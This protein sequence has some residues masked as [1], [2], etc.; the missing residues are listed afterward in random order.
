MQLPIKTKKE[1]LSLIHSHRERIAEYGVVR[2]G[3][4]GS[5]VRDEANENSDVDLFVEFNPSFKTLKNF[6]G[7]ANFF[8]ELSGRKVEIITPESLNKFIGK[9]ITEQVEYVSI[10]A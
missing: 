10:A 5:F 1:L 7:L 2:L 4:F 3:I 9:Y 6:V 8:S